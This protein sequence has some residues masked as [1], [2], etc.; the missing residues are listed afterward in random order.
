MSRA[1]QHAGYKA[2]R[3]E[4]FHRVVVTELGTEYMPGHWDIWD[5][6][7][8][9]WTPDQVEEE[10]RRDAITVLS[11]HDNGTTEAVD[12]EAYTWYVIEPKPTEE[13]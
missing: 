12:R 13:Y 8:E 10:L 2:P 11:T 6:Y 7:A 5:R 1:M 3:R 9:Y 4:D